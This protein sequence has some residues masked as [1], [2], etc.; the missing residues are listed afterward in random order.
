LRRLDAVEFFL[1]DRARRDRVRQDLRAAGDLA[2]ALT[3]LVLGRG[4]PR[5]LAQLRDGLKAGDRAA[6]CLGGGA[7]APAEIAA[8][9]AALTLAAHAG[10]AELAAALEAA[11]ASE[12]PLLARDGGFIAAGYD[13]ELDEARALRDDSRKVIAALQASYA[14]ETG[15]AG[16]KLK[17]NGVLGYHIDATPKQ[18]E[19]LTAPPHNARF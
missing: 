13:A 7:D 15:I 17:H 16:L 6:G 19:T 5:D 18:A 9:A 2:R 1:S 12:L 10:A 8:A 14:E 4:G 11:L 3:R